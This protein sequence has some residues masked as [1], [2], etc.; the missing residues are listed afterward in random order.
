MTTGQQEFPGED[1]TEILASVVK[2]HPDWQALPPSVP[3]NIRTVLLRCLQ[4]DIRK[5]MRDAGDIAIELE[6]AAAEPV[7]PIDNS[8]TS[9]FILSRRSVLVGLAGLLIGGTITGTAVW[10]LKP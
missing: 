2:G 4:K 7:T 9:P 5:R 8:A 6:Q 3:P 1:T 10:R